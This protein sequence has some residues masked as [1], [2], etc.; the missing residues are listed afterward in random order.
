MSTV[1]SMVK[2]IANMRAELVSS[3]WRE[4]HIV[5]KLTA[6]SYDSLIDELVMGGAITTVPK[7][8]SPIML[9]NDVRVE[10]SE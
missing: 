8:R 7:T 2:H 10:C 1:M 5:V 6:A 3:G 4:G 9:M